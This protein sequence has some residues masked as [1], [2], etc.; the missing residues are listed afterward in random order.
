MPVFQLTPL[1]TVLKMDMLGARR[2]DDRDRS[3]S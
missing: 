3:H 1:C 2:K